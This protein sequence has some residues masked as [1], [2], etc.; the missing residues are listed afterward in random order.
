MKKLLSL[1]LCLSL[2]I[3][4]CVTQA[5]A[6]LIGDVNY[7]GNLSISDAREVL[8]AIAN[9]TQDELANADVN[10]DGKVSI[11]DA[12]TIIVAVANGE[13]LGYNEIDYTAEQSLSEMAFD[14][15]KYNLL[16]SEDGNANT[17]ANSLTFAALNAM[18]AEGAD[19]ESA[20]I[21]NDLFFYGNRNEAMDIVESYT[22]ISDITLAN[23][24]FVRDGF[25]IKTTYTDSLK[26][27]FNADIFTNKAF[28]QTTVEEINN[29]SFNKTN[30][31]VGSPV[32]SL[33]I[34]S[35]LVL[36][37]VSTFSAN[38]LFP[39]NK[40]ATKEDVFTNADGSKK[41][42]QMMTEYPAAIGDYNGNTVY[43]KS[44]ENERFKFIAVMPD[45]DIVEYTFNF[46]CETLH[47][48]L[49]KTLMCQDVI[50]VCLPKFS[51]ENEIDFTDVYKFYEINFSNISDTELTIGP[52]KQKN[53]VSI[54][55]NGV[56]AASAAQ[57]VISTEVVD[58]TVKFD[59]PFMYMIVDT[60]NE[61][62]L[63]SGT[64]CNIGE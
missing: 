30:G 63:Y 52:V 34:E 21:L 27:K 1:I 25:D 33:D 3:V 56:C 46:N 26:L 20:K 50:K 10:F 9:G 43:M 29:W 59:R 57:A 14:V 39:F 23:S 42:V 51:I 19:D 35:N 7:D 32:N 44:F 31:L 62:A 16:L 38:W 37:S 15:M 4:P 24:A 12:R 53:V 55:E 41:T 40:D 48:I 28:D 11:L 36:N 22:D 6:S 18:I 58:R 61:V 60:E 5:H 49:T 54:D 8:V 45:E 13:D 2:M 64:V 17:T 47:N